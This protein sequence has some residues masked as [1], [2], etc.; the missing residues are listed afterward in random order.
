MTSRSIGRL[1]RFQKNIE[2]DTIPV[3]LLRDELLNGEI[4]YPGFPTAYGPELNPDETA[5]RYEPVARIAVAVVW[6]RCDG[7]CIDP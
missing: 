3:T 5:I 4:F 7:P 2:T 6:R 1:A